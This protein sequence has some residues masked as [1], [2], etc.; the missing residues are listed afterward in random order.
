MAVPILYGVIY[1]EARKQARRVINQYMQV[2]TNLPSRQHQTDKATR[3]VG[4]VLITTL[5][6]WLPILMLFP[7]IFATS[8]NDG[9]ILKAMLWCLTPAC[10]S[11]CINPFIYF[12]KFRKFRR[13]VRKLF[14]GVQKHVGG[15]YLANTKRRNGRVIP[16]AQAG[17]STIATRRSA[18]QE[19]QGTEEVHSHK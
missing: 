10:I 11:S 6:C 7:F 16:I 3:G 18:W 14:Q 2:T 9:E 5:L 1:K 15:S 13:N 12:Y 19:D 4:L 17:N 8:Q